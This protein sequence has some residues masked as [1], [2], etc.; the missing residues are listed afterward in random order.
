MGKKQTYDFDFFNLKVKNTNKQTNIKDR[1]NETKLHR[2]IVTKK[3]KKRTNKEG[4]RKR[5]RK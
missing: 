5:E 4:E 1:E 2:A 3:Y